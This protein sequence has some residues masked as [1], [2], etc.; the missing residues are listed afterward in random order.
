MDDPSRVLTLVI[1][2]LLISLILVILC[3]MMVLRFL[4]HS[5]TGLD[6][7][8]ARYN[9]PDIPSGQEFARQTIKIGALYYRN[10]VRIVIA[11]EGLFLGFSLPF[12]WSAGERVLIPWDQIS[13]DGYDRMFWIQAPRLK[14]LS[15]E[16]V[17]V[18]VPGKT[19]SLLPIF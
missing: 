13:R 11:P 18:I 12:P 7:L 15:P 3:V 2:I 8:V 16:P 5:K 1:A 19:D 9:A 14:V 4:A 10:C 6:I 17:I